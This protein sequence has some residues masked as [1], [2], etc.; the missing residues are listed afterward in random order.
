[1]LFEVLSP[2]NHDKFMKCIGLNKK[3]IIMQAPMGQDQVSRRVTSPVTSSIFH[4]S[5]MLFGNM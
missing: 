1:M 2:E 5:Q 4:P 3:S